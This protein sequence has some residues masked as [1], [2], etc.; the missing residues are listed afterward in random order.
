MAKKY[1]S[2]N[3]FIVYQITNKLNEMIYIGCHITNNINDNYMGSGT[4]IKKA[5]KEFGKENFTKEILYVFDN[6][7]EMLDKENELVNRQFI[8][9]NKTYNIIIG[10]G[11]F[12]PIDCVTVKDKNNNIFNV[13]INDPR[14]LSGE[15]V[16]INKG[17][18]VVKDKNNNH[19]QINVNELN[20]DDYTYLRKGKVT[21]IDRN[22]KSFSV[23]VNDPRYLSKEL[24]SV[25]TDFI[26]VKDKNNNI[27][28]T[29]VNDPK[30]ISGEFVSVNKDKI[31]VKDNKGNNYS[32]YKDDPRFLSGELKYINIGKIAVKDKDGNKFQIDKN[33]SRFLSGELVNTNK[34][35]VRTEETKLKYKIAKKLYFENN[36]GTTTGKKWIYNPNLRIN[37]FINLNELDGYLTNGWMTGYKREYYKK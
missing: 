32:V 27:I 4:N 35:K 14:Y 37:K 25:S 11:G 22:N 21:V 29:K 1:N 18:I 5:I 20:T 12:F 8:A 15:L 33:D 17:K 10:G 3:K 16:S 7:Q 2:F 28:R 30:Y 9:D 26:M 36:P 19:I 34:G 31:I 13:N 6:E 23:D 24:K